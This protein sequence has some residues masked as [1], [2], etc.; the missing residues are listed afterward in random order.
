MWVPP[1]RYPHP[2]RIVVMVYGTDGHLIRES[3]I[4]LRSYDGV[5]DALTKKFKLRDV[6]YVLLNE[7][8]DEVVDDNNVVARM[9]YRL[10]PRDLKQQVVSF[11]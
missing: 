5:K 1:N 11:R 6:E 4:V 10:W 9:A 7:T 2:Y 8:S 3:I